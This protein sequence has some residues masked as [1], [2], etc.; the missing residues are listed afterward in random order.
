MILRHYELDKRER[1]ALAISL[2]KATRKMNVRLLIAGDAGLAQ[3][4][5]A[6]GLHLPSWMARRGDVWGHQ[7]KPGWLITAAAHNEIELRTAAKIGVDAALL[8]P[9]FP[10]ASH[11][12]APC[13][14][15]VRFARLS[16]GAGIPVYALGGLSDKSLKRLR[17]TPNMFGWAGVS[18]F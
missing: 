1:L 17:G 11:A 6:D 3:E 12:G 5:A 2:R 7:R 18:G 10:T 4:V 16:T 13:L 8:S 14:G 15:A 9:V